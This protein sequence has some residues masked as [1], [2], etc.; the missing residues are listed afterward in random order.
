MP[1]I[2]E[3]QHL[4]KR[5]ALGAA[6]AKEDNLR[7][8]ITEGVKSAWRTV[9]GSKSVEN[10]DDPGFLWS[11]RDVNFDVNTGDVLGIVGVNGAGKSTLLK[12]LSR[13]TDPTEGLVKLRGR[14]ASLLEVGTGFHPDLTGR[15]N[16]Y[17]N[18]VM[19]GMTRREVQAKFDEI[20]A[21]AEL[22]KFLDTQVKHYSS[23]MYVRLG[24][25]VA[26]HLNP[27]ILVVDEV[28][29]VGDMA[30]QKK[31]LGKMSEF[32]QGGRTVLFVSHNM[33]AVE[34]L[35]QRG[36]VLHHGKLVLDGTAKDA[37]QYYVH[38]IASRNAGDNAHRVDL[39][40]APGRRARS[41]PSIQELALY[42]AGDRPVNG[43]LPIGSP[44]RLQVKFKVPPATPDFDIRV[45]F[46][47]LFG[48]VVFTARSSYEPNRNWASASGEQN[49]VCDIPAL[50][51]TPAEYRLDVALAIGNSLIDYVE[52]AVSLSVIESDYY[53]T[54]QPP[55]VGL[56]VMEHHWSDAGS[57]GRVREE[58]RSLAG[59]SG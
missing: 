24:F 14:M 35:C 55:S 41:R 3:V 32:G 15:E 13:I 46:L 18:G 38:N 5:Y 37:I 54:G 30:F 20:V 50:C 17:L 51:L 8:I 53:G 28:L 31:C 52:N 42:T 39:R 11:L 49:F 36:I 25:A 12:I 56:C 10:S 9:T 23:G 19:L 1:P 6:R 7:G 47:T 21:F 4:S 44:L 40:N 34:N 57:D 22:E 29:A 45:N 48:Q 59:G 26:A 2:I 33:A 16:I 58:S 27:E 43:I